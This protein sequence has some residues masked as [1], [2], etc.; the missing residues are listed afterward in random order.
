MPNFT[1][2][3]IKKLPR[4]NFDWISWSDENP[5]LNCLSY[6]DKNTAIIAYYNIYNKTK[7][8]VVYFTGRPIYR[9]TRRGGIKLAF[10]DYEYFK[11]RER[12]DG[13]IVW[14][15]INFTG[16]HFKRCSTKA[17]TKYSSPTAQIAL[18]GMHNHVP[19]IL[20]AKCNFFGFLSHISH[21]RVWITVITLK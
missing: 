2:T 18:Q 4:T 5:Q 19:R 1:R 21:T 20:A 17:Y 7:W 16:K 13:V 3:D 11:E 8:F 9:K 14:R 6:R 12:H 10:N 15:C